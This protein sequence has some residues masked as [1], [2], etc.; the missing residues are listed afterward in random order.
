MKK[1]VLILKIILSLS[2]MVALGWLIGSIIAIKI[3]C[4][5]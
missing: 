4:G 2:G 1:W 3:E 5:G